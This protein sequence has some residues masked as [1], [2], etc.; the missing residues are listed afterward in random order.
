MCPQCKQVRTYPE[1]NNTCSPACAAAARS[2]DGV[3]KQTGWVALDRVRMTPLTRSFMMRNA[4]LMQAE[5]DALK[6]DAKRS[7]P[8]LP[9]PKRTRRAG[10]SGHM[11][12][13]S[14]PDLHMGKLAWAKETGHQ[15]YDSGIAAKLFRDAV[16]TLV[17]RTEAFNPEQICL[18]VGND[19]LN[20]DNVQHTTTHGTPQHSDVR[21]QKTFRTTRMMV[22]DAIRTL[23]QISPVRVV[24]VP[25]NHDT[26]SIWHL[27][28]S[29]ECLFEGQR[30]VVIENNPTSRKYFRW[31]QVMLMWTHGDKGKHDKYP[32]LMAKEQREMFGACTWHEVHLGHLH[33]VSLRELNGVR[34]RI[35]PSLCA[36]DAWHAEMGYVGNIRSAEGYVWDHDGLVSV[37]T[38]TAPDYDVRVLA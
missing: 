28:D 29:L 21:Y 38:Y 9:Q 2:K 33:Q 31:G 17:R 23:R 35:L 27:G 8:R 7:L 26:L 22:A 12:E 14:I 5:V 25:G 34:V 6:A 32:L 36:A 3:V 10:R 1:R 11:L 24:M 20:T 13:L 19:L 18:V 16:D 15:N 37:A 30:D 4:A